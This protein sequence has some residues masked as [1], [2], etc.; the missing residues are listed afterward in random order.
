MPLVK[1]EI[2]KGKTK[3]YKKQLLESIHTALINTLEIEDDDRFQRIYEL[4]ID[5]FE[6]RSSKTDKFTLIELTLLPG[7]SKEVKG[8][9]IKEI[10]CCLKKNLGI[11]ETDVLIIMHELPLDN[12]GYYGV[13]ASELVL[14]YKKN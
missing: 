6:R 10:T 11:E 8:N 13:Q 7:R 1:V 9:V 5:N 14:H 4:D 2:I 12:W 3:E